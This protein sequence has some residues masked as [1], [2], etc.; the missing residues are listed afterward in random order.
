[1]VAGSTP[2]NSPSR[3][4]PISSGKAGS[5]QALDFS[6]LLGVKPSPA[7]PKIV[8]PSSG[9]SIYGT[10]AAATTSTYRERSDSDLAREL[11]GKFDT[12][13]NMTSW[14]DFKHDSAPGLDDKK[15]DGRERSKKIDGRERSDSELARLSVFVYAILVF[16]PFFF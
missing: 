15:F 13:L 9:S 1:M 14:A 16:F 5:V 2:I 8:M 12:E 10:P 6:S 4:P 11:Q 7:D 3:L